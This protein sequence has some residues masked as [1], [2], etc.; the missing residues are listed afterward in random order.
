MNTSTKRPKR[1]LGIFTTY[2]TKS[3]KLTA[4]AIRQRFIIMILSSQNSPTDRTRTS[5]AQ[6]IASKNGKKIWKNIYSAIFRDLEVLISC[7]L[8]EEEGRLPLKRGPKA[9]QEQGT[10][11]YRLSYEGRII[12]LSLDTDMEEVERGSNGGSRERIRE[13]LSEIPID[14]DVRKMLLK[15]E[16][17]FPSFTCELIKKYVIAYCKGRIKN[18]FP[19][20]YNSFKGI[21]KDKDV[22]I[23]KEF[24]EFGNISESERKSILN[25][26]DKL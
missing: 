11:Y 16:R 25:F 20:D 1:E 21:I 9:I 7:G 17:C 12:S 6:K 13:V 23:Y 8:V 19:L 14:K 18:I 3:T 2:K 24:L 4:E 15:L 10:P 5:L 22:H 26:L